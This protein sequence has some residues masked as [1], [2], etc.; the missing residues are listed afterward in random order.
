MTSRLILLTLLTLHPDI[1]VISKSL[2]LFIFDNMV[3][4][5]K[6]AKI[7]NR[8]NLV[9]HL[10]QDTNGEVTNSQLYTTKESQEVSAFPAGDH[11]AQINRRAQRHNKHKTEKT[12]K[13]STKGVWPWNCQ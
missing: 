12:Y 11:R 4:V 1:W 8:Y 7:R 6:C 2:I 5:S 3:T 9:P 13:I 10:S